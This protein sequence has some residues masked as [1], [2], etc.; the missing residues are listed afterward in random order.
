VTGR[1]QLW[2]E[3]TAAKAAMA[4]SSPGSGG[5]YHDDGSVNGTANV[6][7]AAAAVGPFPFPSHHCS[8]CSACGNLLIIVVKAVVPC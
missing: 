4:A 5:Q 3:A 2:R 6:P 7:A 8:P 1:H